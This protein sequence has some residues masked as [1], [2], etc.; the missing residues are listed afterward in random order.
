MYEI[1]SKGFKLTYTNLPN[2]D[3]KHPIIFEN[4]LVNPIFHQKLQFD[5][6][7]TLIGIKW[8]LRG[9]VLVVKHR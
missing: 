2:K 6:N 5:I 7:V 4:S 9:P 1:L 3:A 8:G